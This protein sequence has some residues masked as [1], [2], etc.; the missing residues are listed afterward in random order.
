M[1]AQ[2]ARLQRFVINGRVAT[3]KPAACQYPQYASAVLVYGGSGRA[4]WVADSGGNGALLPGGSHAASQ[5]KADR[6][7]G[8]KGVEQ[9]ARRQK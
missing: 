6:C 7:L 3:A 9:Q 1:I 8:R 2:L 4:F 5:V